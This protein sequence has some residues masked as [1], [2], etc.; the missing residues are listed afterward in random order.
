MAKL[1]RLGYMFSNELSPLQPVRLGL[2]YRYDKDN[3]QAKQ[4]NVRK[5]Y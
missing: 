4:R 1:D 3:K 5:D 2:V